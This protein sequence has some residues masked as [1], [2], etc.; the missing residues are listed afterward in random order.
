M[1]QAPKQHAWYATGMKGIPWA[2]CGKCG[3]IKLNNPRTKKRAK[4]ACP[5]AQEDK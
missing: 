4:Q 5:G 2:V 1:E 3:L